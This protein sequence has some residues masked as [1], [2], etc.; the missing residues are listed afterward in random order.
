[1]ETFAVIEVRDDVGDIQG[2]NVR[3]LAQI[4]ESLIDRGVVCLKFHK[5]CAC[6]GFRV[7][8][9]R[10]IISVWM[11]WFFPLKDGKKRSYLG[12]GVV[13]PWYKTIFWS[14]KKKKAS[15]NEYNAAL[16]NVVEKIKI[17]LKGNLCY[18][19][20]EWMTFDEAWRLL[21]KDLPK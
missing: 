7:K 19:R 3:L 10:D 8:I 6:D 16:E 4:K 12:C 21:E 18:T 2:L 9:G 11:F 15:L 17:I 20:A 13:N 14:Q 1:M 5:G